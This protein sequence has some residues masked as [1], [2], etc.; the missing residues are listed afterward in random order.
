M[1]ASRYSLT[2]PSPI[3]P[4]QYGKHN[5]LEFIHEINHSAWTQAL[6]KCGPTKHQAPSLEAEKAP[7]AHI[8]LPVPPLA[9]E[10]ATKCHSQMR[11]ASSQGGWYTNSGDI[12]RI[13]VNVLETEGGRGGSQFA[14]EMLISLNN[15]KHVFN[16]AKAILTT[17]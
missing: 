6:I 11:A 12:L 14:T 13:Y 7:P 15:K 1:E 8:A 10:V 4:H 3:A 2:S 5:H 9:S 17:E 16:V